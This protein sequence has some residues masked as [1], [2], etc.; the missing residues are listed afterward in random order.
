MKNREQKRIRKVLPVLIMIITAAAILGMS[1]CV[2]PPEYPT[3]DVEFS[4]KSGI[5]VAEASFDTSF[6]REEYIILGSIS[7]EGR[8]EYR[9]VE[10]GVK[11]EEEKLPFWKKPKQPSYFVYDVL[12][13]DRS[14][15]TWT[16]EGMDVIQPLADDDNDGYNELSRG[17]RDYLQQIETI[18]ARI[19]LYNA[20]E[21]M[22][23]ADAILLPKYQ[24]NYEMVDKYRHETIGKERVIDRD[25]KAVT[26]T[27]TGKAIRI[28]SD[29]ELYQTYREFP[30]I[31]RADS[32]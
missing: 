8:V 15:G 17:E 28:K 20:L 21:K 16:D 31:F 19:A 24:F 14:F 27:V 13:Y 22:P 7:G 29:E 12:D 2:S 23:E 32:E 9:I 5:R 26:A 4:K 6:S 10:D 30:E 3:E 18:A 25:I 1:G 11:P